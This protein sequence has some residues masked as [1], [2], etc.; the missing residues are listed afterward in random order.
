MYFIANGECEVIVKDILDTDEW[1]AFLKSGS[2]FGE[3]A[4]VYNIPRTASV[5]ALNHWTLAKLN[6]AHF[7][8][9]I[10]N[11]PSIL[12]RLKIGTLNY[13]D[14]IKLFIQEML[15][16]IK[17]FSNLSDPII[18]EL[19]Y[20]LDIDTYSPDQLIYTPGTIAS[21]ILFLVKG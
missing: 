13:R 6:K 7:D 14:K 18:E 1:T 12:S 11:F 15:K 5:M 17:Y 9:L 4:L 19:S 20:S 16:K 2:H 10:V 3:I 8:E 21:D